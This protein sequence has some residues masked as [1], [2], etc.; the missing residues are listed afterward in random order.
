[1]GENGGEW[2]RTEENGSGERRMTGEGSTA[3]TDSVHIMS[4]CKPI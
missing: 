2:E 4:I 3:Y 1:M